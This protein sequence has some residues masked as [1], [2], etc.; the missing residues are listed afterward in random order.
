[1]KTLYF[2][3]AMISLSDI[4]AARE[5]IAPFIH[6]TPLIPSN[7]LSALSGAEVFLKLE[8]LQKTGSFKVRGAFN[9]LLSVTEPRVIAASMGNHAQAVAF[10]AG[11]LGKQS[12]IVIP[13][14][15]GSNERIRRRG[16]AP[17]RAVQRRIGLR[18]YPKGCALHS[19]L[20]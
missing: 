14:Q 1:V 9:K 17:R 10:A 4:Q 6:R 16:G 5:R 11:K 13:G 3:V 15:A 2:Q 20:R 7:S 8:N 18:S 12:V 19:S